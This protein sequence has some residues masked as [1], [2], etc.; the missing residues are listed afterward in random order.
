MRA[1]ATAFAT[2]IR[3]F[4]PRHGRSQIPRVDFRR[5][6]AEPSF[7][8]HVSSQ[9]EL[10]TEEINQA[11]KARIDAGGF[12]GAKTPKAPAASK[13]KA[14]PKAK[15][16]KG[17]AAAPIVV[18]E[19]ICR[20]V[21]R[22]WP[23]EGGWFDA[24]ITDYRPTTNE[25]CL[26]YEINTPNET[27]E[28]ADIS[29]FDGRE[30]KLLE[31]RVNIEDLK[32]YSQGM[33]VGAETATHNQAIVATHAAVGDVNKIVQK[34]AKTADVDKIVEAKGTLSAQEEA[35]GRSSP[36]ST[37]TATATRINRGE[38]LWV[39]EGEERRTL[40]TGTYYFYRESIS[41]LP[42]L[43][44]SST[45]VAS[46]FASALVSHLLVPPPMFLPAVYHLASLSG[47]TPAAYPNT[48]SWFSA[49]TLA[50]PG[51]PPPRAG[52]HGRI[53]D[54]R[55]PWRLRSRFTSS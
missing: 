33:K 25:H 42:G 49:V 13:P 20:R 44:R 52:G 40:S 24:I 50:T 38:S 7:P 47:A 53:H 51:V 1:R 43:H 10:E 21:Q 26:T 12:T 45:F 16:P 23:D 30:F 35:L 11:A 3:G 5:A 46:A 54:A 37:A 6:K 55:H 48:M 4:P 9:G 18:N 15:T 36:L 19:L 34:A 39:R 22:F 2:P 29:Q 31:D 32:F 27:F 41:K 14:A 8:S 28:W 17:P